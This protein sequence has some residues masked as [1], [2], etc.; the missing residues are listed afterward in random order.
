[1]LNACKNKTRTDNLRN[2]KKAMEK[3]RDFIN[4]YEYK[5]TEN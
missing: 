3:I 4:Y 1:M 5:I 2:N